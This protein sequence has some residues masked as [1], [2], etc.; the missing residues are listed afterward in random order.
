[1]TPDVHIFTRSKLSWITLPDSVP[2][3]EVYYDMKALWPT[4]SLERLAAILPAPDSD[5]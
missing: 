1:V 2:A 4:A 3:F 5:A